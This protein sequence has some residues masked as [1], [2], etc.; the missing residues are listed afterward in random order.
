MINTWRS[1]LKRGV[2]PNISKDKIILLLLAILIITDN[3]EITGK[4][5]VD[6]RF[7]P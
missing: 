1:E 6:K 4:I 5:V 3:N 7:K 2:V